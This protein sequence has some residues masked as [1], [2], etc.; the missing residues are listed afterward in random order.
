MVA[1]FSGSGQEGSFDSKS[2]RAG[3]EKHITPQAGKLIERRAG[4]T[5]TRKGN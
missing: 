1:H 5:S 3:Y 2:R 4:C